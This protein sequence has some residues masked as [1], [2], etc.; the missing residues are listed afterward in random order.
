MATVIARKNII[1]NLLTK[2]DTKGIDD[3]DKKVGGLKKRFEGVRSVFSGILLADIAK[4]IIRNVGEIGKSIITLGGDTEQT[5]LQF[6]QLIG[7]AETTNFILSELDKLSISTPFTPT[8]LEN[9]TKNLLNYGIAVED[10]LDATGRLG[11]LSLGDAAKFSAL[12]EA[13]GKA[14]AR[15]KVTNETLEL[16]ANNGVPILDLLGDSLGVASAEVINLASKGQ[17]GFSDLEEAIKTATDEGGQFFNALVN[18]SQSLNGLLSTATGL[19]Q[20]MGKRIGTAL[21]P[22]LKPI[23]SGFNEIG[24]A[25]VNSIEK[26]QGRITAIAKAVFEFG[27][28]IIRFVRQAIGPVVEG[29][30]NFGSAIGGVINGTG[31]LQDLVNFLARSFVVI[32]EGI[33]FAITQFSNLVRFVS[34]NSD[35]GLLKPVRDLISV[36][37]ALPAIIAGTVASIRQLGENLF[38]F[39]ARVPIQAAILRER[40]RDFSVF[41]DGADPFKI[42]ALEDQ[43][44][45]FAG[46]SVV[47][48]F[49]EEFDRIQDIN[50]E[51]PTLDTPEN[52]EK[53]SNSGFELGKTAG[54]AVDEGFK[55][56]VSLVE[57]SIAFFE[58]AVSD[59][60]KKLNNTN[61]GDIALLT[62]LSDDLLKAQQD[63]FVARQVFDQFKRTVEDLP[64]LD[65]V[66]LT[67]TSTI[68]DLDGD[69][70]FTRLDLINRIL[71]SRDDIQNALDQGNVNAPLLNRLLGLDDEGL[72]EFKGLLN[73]A[74]STSVAAINEILQAEQEA[75]T[76][77]LE[78]QEMRVERAR[79][80][81]IQG[82]DEQLKIELDRL[83]TLQAANEQAQERREQL[84]RLQIITA[85]AVA[86]AESI[87][88]IAQAAALPPPANI[89]AIAATSAALGLQIAAIASTINSG[90]NDL[91]AFKDGVEVFKGKGTERSDS[92]LV[93]VSVNEGILD[94]KTNANRL[95]LGLTKDNINSMATY[96]QDNTPMPTASINPEYLTT[97]S[98]GSNQTDLT[99]LRN[100]LNSIK[101]AIQ[102]QDTP[103]TT[104]IN[105]AP[106]AE[107]WY[108]RT[109]DGIKTT[110]RL[111]D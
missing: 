106:N 92:N 14:N 28:T 70:G 66:S 99:P 95:K 42:K 21:L 2:A 39:F 59:L 94:A 48:A 12:T 74:V 6:D 67:A 108:T 3:V 77:R 27:G 10:V 68:T 16:F 1:L 58:K 40:L 61:V 20:S 54:E 11:D 72:D 96:K 31:A 63:L 88:A 90:F 7:D 15:V 111:H 105:K 82:N 65:P 97:L 71:Q 81:A 24:F 73:D 30:R 26:N 25:I 23:V 47:D 86:A 43:L 85:Q 19:I 107:T 69:S 17:I 4:G 64:E 44:E 78:A 5:R 84:A 35:S 51:L 53:I 93:R 41:G 56:G 55:K 62:K 91:P 100:D 45:Q 38:N 37:Q 101:L 57:N 89:I 9:G 50:V 49:Q 109:L 98:K 103:K 60:Q 22:V 32:G 76:L 46:G 29:L 87:R 18:Q 52:K 104:I 36:F 75:I 8:D 102:N 79:E 83:N 33:G 13:Y 80:L 34:R 110:K